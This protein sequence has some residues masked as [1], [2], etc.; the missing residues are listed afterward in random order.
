MT[1]FTVWI[2]NSAK[3][4]HTESTNLI[5]H[6]LIHIC[7]DCIQLMGVGKLKPTELETTAGVR[8]ARPLKM[9]SYPITH[10]K[11]AGF[12]MLS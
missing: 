4:Q 10:N 1:P 6:F 7:L 8:D 11:Q 9:F 5:A 12:T 2:V 3:L